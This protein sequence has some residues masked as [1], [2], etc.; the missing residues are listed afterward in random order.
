M[1]KVLFDE[2]FNGPILSGIRRR[3]PD[4]DILRCLDAGLSG[5]ADPEILAFAAAEGRMVI[6]HG[7][8]TMPG[9]AVERIDAGLPMPGIFIVPRR[10]SR[11]DVIDEILILIEDSRPDDWDNIVTFLPIL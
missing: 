9:Y 6:S 10:L 3:R 5:R 4:L 2:D 7:L 1:L 11:R 8:R